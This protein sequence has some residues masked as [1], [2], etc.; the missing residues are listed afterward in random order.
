LF[1][2]FVAKILT[3]FLISE[4]KLPVPVMTDIPVKENKLNHGLAKATRLKSSVAF[5]FELLKR[6]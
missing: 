1:I 4:L 6:V 2:N 5:I 3:C